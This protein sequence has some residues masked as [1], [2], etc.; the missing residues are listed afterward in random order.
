LAED[1]FA[2]YRDAAFLDRLRLGHL[3]SRLSAFWPARGPQWDALGLAGDS[4]VLV[5]AKAH[6]KEFLSDATKAQPDSRLQIEQAFRQVQQD[7]GVS[8][9][10]DWT[11]LFYQYA[12]RIAHLWW[13]R[14][15]GVEAHLMFVSFLG[16]DDPNI[17]GPHEPETWQALF[18]AADYALGLPARHRLSRFIHHVM[19][20]VADL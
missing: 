14:E 7:L 6:V 4:P 16:D 19:P 17:R 5:E 10:S 12:N 20:R 2:E 8:G 18:A 9:S 11:Q 3:S 15:Q 13:L 1:G